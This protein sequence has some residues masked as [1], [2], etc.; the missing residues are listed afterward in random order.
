MNATMCSFAGTMCNTSLSAEEENFIKI[1]KIILEAVPKHLRNLFVDKWDQK[2]QNN[3]WRSDSASGKF[4][5]NQIPNAAK[6]GRIGEYSNKLKSGKENEWDTSTL[7]YTMLYSQLNLIPNCRP[8]GKRSAP[9]LVSEEID[10]IRKIRNEFFAD[11]PTMK[12]S[13]A[14][15][16]DIAWKINSVARNA[17][18]AN[19]E[20]EIC[21]IVRS[22]ITTK[23]TDQLMHQLLM[24]KNR[25]D[26]FEKAL[27]GK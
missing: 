13:S 14:T 15:F 5:F 8:D 22:Q 6:N 25:N 7:V 19:A 20:N 16:V 3:K 4:L 17:F 18:G 26:E 23:V 10:I 9:L 1:T 12:C 21:D 27:R 24:E 11:V 2:Y